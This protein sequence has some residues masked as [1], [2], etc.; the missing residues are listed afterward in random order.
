MFRLVGLSEFSHKLSESPRLKFRTAWLTFGGLALAAALLMSVG[1]SARLIL[2]A[3]LVALI[4]FHYLTFCLIRHFEER[5]QNR[6]TEMEKLGTEIRLSSDLQ[7][8][9]V[10]VLLDFLRRKGINR[11]SESELHRLVFTVRG[12]LPTRMKFVEHPTAYSNQ[13]FEC[14]RALERN[15][16]VDELIYVHDGWAPKHLYEVTRIGQLKA[17]EVEERMRTQRSFALDPL[18]DS[19]SESVEGQAAITSL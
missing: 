9:S 16:L 10:L 4:P 12:L 1:I 19:L 7:Q 15:R 2:P 6:R 11:I 5:L 14:L 18:F 8:E 3:M 13:L 17:S